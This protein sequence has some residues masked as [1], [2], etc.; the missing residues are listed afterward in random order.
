MKSGPGKSTLPCPTLP[1]SPARFHPAHRLVP[2]S[3]KE[4]ITALLKKT[5]REKPWGTLRMTR[6]AHEAARPW[7][8]AGMPRQR[9]E[10]L[11][12]LIPDDAVDA[13]KLEAEADRL[14][15]SDIWGGGRRGGPD[16]IEDHPRHN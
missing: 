11:V 12:P 16:R 13:R 3:S 6:R 14:G 10:E 8:S 4:L 7:L 9:G 1:R 5:K 2:A 15:G